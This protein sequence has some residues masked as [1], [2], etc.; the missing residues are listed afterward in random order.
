MTRFI[1]VTQRQ[2]NLLNLWAKLDA[3]NYRMLNLEELKAVMTD[4]G[5]RSQIYFCFIYLYFAVSRNM[6]EYR[7]GRLNGKY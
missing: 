1:S 4:T 2:S 6:L 7:G 5:K 3:S